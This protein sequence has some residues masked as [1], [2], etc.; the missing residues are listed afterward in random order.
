MICRYINSKVHFVK[1]G[2]KYSKRIAEFE[3]GGEVFYSLANLIKD[4]FLKCSGLS[5]IIKLYSCY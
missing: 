5:L 3:T 4:Y 2:F 1:T